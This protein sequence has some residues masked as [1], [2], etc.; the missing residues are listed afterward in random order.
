MF[1]VDVKQECN[2]ATTRSGTAVGLSLFDD[3]NVQLV[4]LKTWAWLFKTNDI[5]S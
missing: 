4:A 5:V 2:N 3:V 1:T